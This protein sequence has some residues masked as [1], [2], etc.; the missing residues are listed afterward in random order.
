MYVSQEIFKHY[1]DL[2][3]YVHVYHVIC[4][5]Y[6]ASG[7]LKWKSFHKFHKLTIIFEN[8]S[9]DTFNNTHII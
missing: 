8:F 3:T 9:L 2:F 6:V 1:N 7:F 4:T 5:I